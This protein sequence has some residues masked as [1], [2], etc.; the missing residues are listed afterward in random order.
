MTAH[1]IPRTAVITI[2][3]GRHEHWW[4]QRR[5]LQRSLPS[6]DLH[7]LIAM[8]D[9]ALAEATRARDSAVL[10]REIPRAPEGLPL[11]AARNLGA[12][13]AVENGADVLVFLDVD[14]LAHPRLVEGYARATEAGATNDRLLSGPVTY[15]PPPPA[16]GYDLDALSALDQPHPARPAPALGEVE[17]G[18]SYDLFWS[19]SFALDRRTW[20]RI[21]GFSDEYV[22]YGGEDTDF[23]QRARGAGVEMAWIGDARAYHQHHPVHRP[24]VE[25]L[26]DILRNARI[27]QKRWG[28]WPMTG[29]LEEFER[30]GLITARADGTD[31]DR[32]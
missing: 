25:H 20:E 17:L 24:P 8:D 28:W 7:V 9:P 10:V 32:T 2:A 6:P 29:W 5:S 30:M 15:L 11:A 3:H 21:G 23:A 4:L 18:G 19:L 14:C 12:A 16:G 22:G 13:T 26:D 27:F 31:W 1:P